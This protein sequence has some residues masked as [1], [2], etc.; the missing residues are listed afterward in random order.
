[1]DYTF[2]NPVTP[3]QKFLLKTFSHVNRFF[4]NLKWNIEIAPKPANDEMITVEQ[5]INMFHFANEMLVHNI[6]GDFVEL[7]TYTGNSSLQIQTILE[8]FKSDKQFHVYDAF[9]LTNDPATNFK[10]I[11][12]ENFKKANLKLPQIHEGFFRETVP[13][14]LPRKLAFIHIDCTT[15]FDQI[16]LMDLILYLLEHIYPRMTSRAICMIMDYHDVNKT[17][18]GLKTYPCVKEAC[19][20]FF[21]DKPEKVHVLYGNHFSHG[22]FRKK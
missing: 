8:N 16:K 4:A 22:Y 21:E 6:P 11:F 10:N 5:R 17:V 15:E 12:I 20:L 2:F 7:G 13:A 1:M 14:E 9:N 18:R 3:K 19:D